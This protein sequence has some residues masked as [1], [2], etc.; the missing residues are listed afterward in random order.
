MYEQLIRYIEEYAQ[1]RLTPAE[2][3]LIKSNFKPMSLKKRA[4]FLQAGAVSKY[5]GFITKGAMRQYCVDDK[6]DEKIVHFYIENHWATDRESFA[7]GKPSL[8]TIEAWEDTDLLLITRE[9]I[10]ALIKQ[11]PALA[12]MTQVMDER[13]AIATHKRLGS[14]IVGSAKM[15]YQEFMTNYPH[16]AQ[17]FPQHQIASF[18]GIT[19][20]TL[21]RVRRQHP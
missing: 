20:E 5:A 8:Y 1:A 3:A 11:V 12:T 2:V 19:K 17:R 4:Y 14:L 13:H 21:S 15:R 18:L 10:Q 16:F 7:S 6:G 9:Q